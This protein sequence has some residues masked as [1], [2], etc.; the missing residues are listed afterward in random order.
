VSCA[1]VENPCPTDC[2]ALTGKHKDLHRVRLGDYRNVYKVEGAE[3]AVFM[4]KI[5]TRGGAYQ[6]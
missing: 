1:L 4:V 5:D 6:E 2:K 3:F